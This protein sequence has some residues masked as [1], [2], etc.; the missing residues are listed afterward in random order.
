[1][2]WGYSGRKG[3]DGQ[4]KKIGNWI[5]KGKREKV[6]NTKDE[7][8]Y[9]Q[10][11]KKG[12]GAPRPHV[13]P[14]TDGWLD[15]GGKRS[16]SH[17]AVRKVIRIDTWASESI[18]YFKTFSEADNKILQSA[19]AYLL[20]RIQ[21]TQ[22]HRSQDAILMVIWLTNV[23]DLQRIL[24]CCFWTCSVRW[25]ILLAASPAANLRRHPE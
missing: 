9:G 8:V 11:K 22:Q 4:K 3:R 13:G 23:C 24:C 21:L 18:F 7:E 20:T 12:K 15:F 5:R 2:E 10:G 19:Q 25:H 1:M 14:P 6:K 17:Q 16:R